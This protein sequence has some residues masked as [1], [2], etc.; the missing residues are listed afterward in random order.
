MVTR[1]A[2][3][4]VIT[5]GAGDGSRLAPIWWR[6][7]VGFQGTVASLGTVALVRALLLG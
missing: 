7:V 3:G 4:Q 1:G 6:L 2:A 5:T